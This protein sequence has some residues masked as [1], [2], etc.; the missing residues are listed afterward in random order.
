[1]LSTLVLLWVVSMVA[2]DTLYP[3]QHAALMKVFDGAGKNDNTRIK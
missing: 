1:M 2:S 3:A